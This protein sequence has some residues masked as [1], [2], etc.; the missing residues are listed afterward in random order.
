MI[1]YYTPF[2]RY[3]HKDP[4]VVNLWIKGKDFCHEGPKDRRKED[5]EEGSD[6]GW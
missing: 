6:T 1:V 4:I 2:K 5:A 3:V